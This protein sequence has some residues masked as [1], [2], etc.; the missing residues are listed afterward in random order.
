[1]KYFSLSKIF[2]EKKKIKQKNFNYIFYI[3]IYYSNIILLEFYSNFSSF[4]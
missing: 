1:M 3:I 4:L 2:F